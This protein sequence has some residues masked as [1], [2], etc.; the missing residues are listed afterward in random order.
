MQAMSNELKEHLRAQRTCARTG[1]L[2]LTP[3]ALSQALFTTNTSYWCLTLQ[4]LITTNTSYWRLTLQVMSN[5]LK[6]HAQIATRSRIMHENGAPQTHA[7]RPVTNPYYHQ[8]LILAPH[9]AENEPRA[10]GT[11]TRTRRLTMM[12]TSLVGAEMMRAGIRCLK[13]KELRDDE[14]TK[15]GL[16]KATIAGM[17]MAGHEGG[18]G[19]NI[20][21]GFIPLKHACRYNRANIVKLLIELGKADIQARA[22][23]SGD[24]ALHEAASCGSINCIKTLLGPGIYAPSAPRNIHLQT[25]ADLAKQNGHIDCYR[26]IAC[27]IGPTPRYTLHDYYHG[28]ISR[29][30]AQELLLEK[31]DVQSGDFLVRQSIRKRE[32]VVLSMVYIE[33]DEEEIKNFEISYEGDFLSIDDGPYFPC[34][35]SLL[36]HYIR[37]VDG[38]PCLLHLPV[39][40]QVPVPACEL[41]FAPFQRSGSSSSLLSP[42]HDHLSGFPL[43]NVTYNYNNNTNSSRSL[44][45]KPGR[46]H[47][48]MTNNHA[49]ELLNIGKHIST[50]KLSSNPISEPSSSDLFM[51]TQSQETLFTHTE[52]QLNEGTDSIATDPLIYYDSTSIHKGNL[53]NESN[54]VNNDVPPPRPD[55]APLNLNLQTMTQLSINNEMCNATPTMVGNRTEEIFGSISMDSLQVGRSLGTGEFGSVLMALWVSPSGD[56]IDVAVKTLNDNNKVNRQNFMREASIMMNLNHPHIVKLV[57][58]CQG[59]PIA[60]VQELVA[61]GALLDY[62]LDHQEEVTV[63]FHLKLYAAQ[64][65]DGMCYLENKK[66]VHR[67]LAARNILLSSLTMV[68]ISDFGLS[69]AVGVGGKDYYTASEGGR[70]PLKW[71]APES[72]NYGTF[73]HASDIWSYG[74]TL[75]EMYTYGDQPYGEYPGH[76]VI[77]MLEEGKRL[78]QP[79]ECPKGVYELMLRCWDYKPDSRPSF[80]E[81][82]HIFKTKAEYVN[83]K[84]YFR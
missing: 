70:W 52:S 57:G 2:T 6:E 78:P 81:L 61:M 18:G 64:I 72:I 29:N 58:V 17:L 63:E 19:G 10:Q 51:R 82:A 68:K 24:V 35:D 43:P 74:V 67:D 32:T 71:Y 77:E 15:K 59:P 66:F 40:P 12:L 48:P 76:K 7:D 11:C 1:C 53:N 79:K 37:L 28:R 34:L 42:K 4:V 27:H 75:W 60:M 39:H 49:S 21:F 83:I 56:K 69:R 45:T 3:S 31:T 13:C 50:S 54:H 62:L 84:P 44:E 22:T 41:P 16:M 55:R 25:P 36:D 80:K 23:K 8:H 65:A 46:P 33:N 14:A 73:T 5:Q 9:T 20:D 38:L 47:K 30:I 26:A